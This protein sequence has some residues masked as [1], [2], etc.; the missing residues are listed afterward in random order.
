MSDFRVGESDSVVL[1]GHAYGI[2]WFA[3]LA[4]ADGKLAGKIRFFPKTLTRAHFGGWREEEHRR[5]SSD[6]ILWVGSAYVDPL[7]IEHGLD[8]ELIRRVVEYARAAGFAK[9]QAVGW[10]EVLPYAMWGESF[11]ASGYQALGFRA[12]ATTEGCPDAFEHMLNGCH[13]QWCKELV[14]EALKAGLSRKTAHQ[15]QIMELDLTGPVSRTAPS[16]G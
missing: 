5:E 14:E 11:R 4:C 9:V 12:I 10:S 6:D 8:I 1:A 16:S 2:E 15:C 3:L 7:G 13:G